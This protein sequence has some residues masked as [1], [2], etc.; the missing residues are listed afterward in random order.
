MDRYIGVVLFS[1]G[2]VI[3]VKSFAYPFGSLRSPGAGFF[4]L[5]FSFLLMTLAMAIVVHTFLGENGKTTAVPFFAEKGGSQKVLF[6]ILSL[7]AFRYTL[8]RIGLAPTTFLF[9]FFLGK[10]LAHYGWKANG[11]L[12]VTAAALSYFIFQ[13]L[14][15]IPFPTGVFGF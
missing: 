12:A 14:L 8:P 13:F 4:P 2:L 15:K 6:G 3:C 11:A 1:F 7:L 9:V 5:F 10:Y